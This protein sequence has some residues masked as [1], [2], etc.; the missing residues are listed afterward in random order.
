MMAMKKTVAVAFSA[1]M[2][3]L[4]MLVSPGYGC[5]VCGKYVV[6]ETADHSILAIE[7]NNIPSE[8]SQYAVKFFRQN[9]FSVSEI[10]VIGTRTGNMV[11]LDIRGGVL[12]IVFGAGGG[13]SLYE[14]GELVGRYRKK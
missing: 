8:K 13:A 9:D 4:F 11:K 1:S 5:D 6:I 12:L 10:L 2:L 3:L 14:D 7:I